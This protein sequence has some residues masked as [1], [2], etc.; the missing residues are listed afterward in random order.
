MEV[1]L[2]CN[3]VHVSIKAV[4]LTFGT[5]LAIQNSGGL[6]E[7]ETWSKQGWL[8]SRMQGA[9]MLMHCNFLTILPTRPH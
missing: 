1:A 5:L 9:D 7:Q 8:G 3:S 4:Q 6:I 2:Q